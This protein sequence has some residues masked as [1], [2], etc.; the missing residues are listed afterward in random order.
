MWVLLR[1]EFTLKV[2]SWTDCNPTSQI[3]P[4][5][6]I[7]II[8]QANSV[9]NH[10][11]IKRLSYTLDLKHGTECKGLFELSNILQH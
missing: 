6:A 11:V 8:T 5:A 7:V 10:S 2:V 3:I 4:G 9:S 1:E